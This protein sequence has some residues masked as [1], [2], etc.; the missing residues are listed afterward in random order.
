[1]NLPFELNSICSKIWDTVK[2]GLILIDE[3][4]EILLWNQWMVKHSGIS[5]DAAINRPIQSLFHEGITPSPSFRTAI[6]NALSYK[7]PIVLSAALHQSPLPLYASPVAA[8]EQNRMHQSITISPI[9]WDE[10]T[11]RFLIQIVDASIHVKRERVLKSQSD[12]LSKDATTDS[13]TGARNRRYFDDRYEIEFGRAI[14]QGT[15]ISLLMLDV[16]FFKQYNDFY[17]HQAGDD[18]L[19]LIVNMIKAQLHRAT[20]IVVRY[21]GEEFLI[22]L[23]DCTAEGCLHLADKLRTA[24]FDRKIPHQGSGIA[25]CISISVGVATKL[26]ETDCTSATL[27]QTADT[28]LYDAKKTGRNCVQHRMVPI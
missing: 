20:D 4:G 7:L 17:G 8:H 21:G 19:I 6:K 23:P 12:Q 27:L 26:P 18:A 16:D 13:L 24:V 5:V 1:M 9:N 14:R 25:D 15:P 2:F 22:I 11:H 3:K 10:H 28:A